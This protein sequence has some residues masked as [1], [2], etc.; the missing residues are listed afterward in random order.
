VHVHMYVL[1]IWGGV[2]GIGGPGSL[3][4][5][6]PPGPALYRRHQRTTPEPQ[7][8][9]QRKRRGNGSSSSSSELQRS[10]PSRL[11]P[12][13]LTLPFDPAGVA[14]G[15]TVVSETYLSSAVGVAELLRRHSVPLLPPHTPP[16]SNPSRWRRSFTHHWYTFS[17]ISAWDSG[18]GVRESGRGAADRARGGGARQPQASRGG[19]DL[20][21]SRHQPLSSPAET[22]SSSPRRPSRAIS[23]GPCCSALTP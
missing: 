17:G 9:I 15:V 11:L 6:P 14:T 22:T 4:L 7:F 8:K 2:P 19:D 12:F 5:L 13:V 21:F 23:R 3:P 10:Y 18:A 1:C 16:K 20:S